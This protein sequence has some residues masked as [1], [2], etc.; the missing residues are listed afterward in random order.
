MSKIEKNFYLKLL[1]I[2]SWIS[3]FL[4]INLNPVEFF[5]YNLLD[6]VRLILP[7]IL[8]ITFILFRFKKIKINSFFINYSYLFYIIFLLYIFFTLT[9]PQNNNL[10]IYWPLYM[11]LSFFILNILTSSEEKVT[12][13][14]LTII[15][16]AL[17][18]VLYFSASM[19]EMIAKP[20]PHF[21]GVMGGNSSY[22]GLY[23]PPRSSGLAR[24]ALILF[25]FALYFY[26]IKNKKK[27][28]KIL[29]LIA[30]LGTIS[31]VYQSRTVSFIYFLLIIFTILFYFKKFFYDK[32][33]I[34]FALI[35]PLLLNFFYN[36]NIVYDKARKIEKDPE[37]PKNTTVIVKNAFG[38]ILLRD[39]DSY[40]KNPSRFSSD[41]FY[42]WKIAHK[43]I[44]QNYLK[45]YGAQ[46][47]RLL[48]DQSIHNSIL[49]STLS[50]GIL[51]G[52]AIIFIYI[53]SLILLIKFYFTDAYKLNNNILVHFAASI[54]IIICLRSI[55]ETSIAVFS[56]DFLVFIIAFLFFSEQLSKYR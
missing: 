21:Y 48:I 5:E 14:K 19:I 37:K 34:F 6:R 24:L 54:L 45:G 44:K 15:I 28:Y 49:Y 52:L 36:Y 42:N 2:S 43:I 29:F 13:I 22:F 33:L 20:R 9:Y 40:K 17:G 39:Q 4:S 51:G 35:I 11:L 55:L 47:D 32:R 12:I 27:N 31:L 8:T 26:L 3:F 53:Y 50:G 30:F 25:S 18:F 46:A 41:R 10:N 16:I 23:Y 38:N 1:L 56:V 7:I